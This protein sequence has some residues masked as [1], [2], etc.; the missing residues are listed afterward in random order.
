MQKIC[1]KSGKITVR[2]NPISNLPKCFFKQVYNVYKVYNIDEYTLYSVKFESSSFA[3]INIFFK[4][5]CV[6]GSVDGGLI[7][8]SDTVIH[9]KDRERSKLIGPFLD[10]ISELNFSNRN[11]FLNRLSPSYEGTEKMMLII[12]FN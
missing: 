11:I 6:V 9:K 10:R 1:Q 12:G 2:K 5:E 8:K 3:L 7:Q 4:H